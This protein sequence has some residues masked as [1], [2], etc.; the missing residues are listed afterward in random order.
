MSYRLPQIQNDT[1]NPN[2]INIDSNINILSGL[3][4][5]TITGAN[6]YGNGS[7][8]TNINSTFTGG[9]ITGQTIF[10]NGLTANTGYFNSI[11]FN[12]NINPSAFTHIEGSLHWNN[13][14]K[15]LEM[16][17]DVSDFNLQVGQENVIRVVNKTGDDILNGTVVY[18][19]GAQGNR[20][21]IDIAD[22]SAC[23]SSEKVIGVVTHDINNNNN[24]Y[25]T[26]F[27][28]VRDLN[29]SQYSEGDV[30]YLYSGGTLTN[31]KPS[32]INCVIQIGFVVTV[33]S[34]A[35]V[36]LV[37]VET[38]KRLE[39]IYGISNNITGATNN[40]IL[41]FN[42]TSN[43]WEN[44]S[45]ISATTISATTF[46]GDYPMDVCYLTYS[47]TSG[48]TS[49][50]K[51][52][53][54]LSAG[55]WNVTRFNTSYFIDDKDGDVTVIIPDA[56]AL[57]E[58]QRIIVVKPRLVQSGYYIMV[59]TVSNQAV[60]ETSSFY[61]R[62]P[63]DRAELVSVPFGA[64]GSN[65]Y[66]Y[67]ITN[68][69]RSVHEVIEVSI[70]G[71][72]LFSDVKSAVDYVNSYADGPRRIKINPGV[73]T[74][75]D[76]VEINCPYSMVIE[77][78]G[79]EITKFNTS[80]SLSGKP[81]FD[82]VTSCDFRGITF[83]GHSGY[84]LIDDECCLD[85]GVDDLYFEV[86]D[87]VIDSFYKGVEI[88]GDSEVWVFNSIIENCVDGI[89][90]RGGSIGISEMSLFNNI[91]GV[92]F[93][94][95]TTGDT[96]SLQNTIFEVNTSQV[97]INYSDDLVKPKYFLVTNN[98]FYGAGDYISGFTFTSKTQ[99]DLRVET[100]LGL[101]DYKPEAYV[102]VSGNTTATTATSQGVY[103]KPNVLNTSIKQINTIKFSGGSST[104]YFTYISDIERLG[105]FI[106]SG[107]L[108][109]S[110]NNDIVSVALFKNGN[111][112][113]QDIDV[114]C[115]TASQPYPFAFNAVNNMTEDDFFD[116]RVSCTNANTR[117]IILRTLMFEISSK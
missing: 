4:A 87:V 91:N 37:R 11:N 94:A 17:S 14:D 54:L 28:L 95:S 64:N 5:T 16:M 96:L 47:G 97:G 39:D 85:C 57:N 21:T 74:I 89:Y 52:C 92:D 13:S 23:T 98:A 36:I 18:I 100:N 55:T 77:G 20:P 24:G 59:K 32:D 69:T 107:D 22:Y 84:G 53:T 116:I 35:G 33:D 7:N 73:Y 48:T 106:I 30:L 70:G 101:P 3:T 72:Q 104:Q 51:G 10:Q 103:Y 102:W 19:S 86:N 67:R 6:F 12:T 56:S 115:A 110:N 2:L 109:A 83:S 60:A 113:L 105:R 88:E 82:I 79:T 99:S 26:T 65:T 68:G 66:K 9:T 58:G 50:T 81:M 63:N 25:V 8:L 49:G 42:S 111:T 41:S 34:T 90:C 46:Y 44:S 80:Q 15:T 40:Q 114:R 76:T 1:S 27:G 62:N 29:T 45:T 43:L 108:S 93:S 78:F 38:Q 117:T 61:L 75:S 112:K 31:I 71:T